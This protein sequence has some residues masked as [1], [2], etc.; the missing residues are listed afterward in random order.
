M[1]KASERAEQ[2]ARISAESL[3]VLASLDSRLPRESGAEPV[4]FPLATRFHSGLRQ[5]GRR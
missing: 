2:Y 3:G 4:Q 5:I 1:P